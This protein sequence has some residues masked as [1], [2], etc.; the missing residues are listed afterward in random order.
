LGMANFHVRIVA[1]LRAI[2]PVSFFLLSLIKRYHQSD[3]LMTFGIVIQLSAL[4]FT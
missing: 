4:L 2:E 1:S 3:K